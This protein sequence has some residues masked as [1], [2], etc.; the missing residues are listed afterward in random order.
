MSLSYLYL[1]IKFHYNTS[2][3]YNEPNT[4]IGYWKRFFDD[5]NRNKVPSQRPD[6]LIRTSKTIEQREMHALKKEI[7]AYR[8]L[9]LNEQQK[10]GC[11]VAE[12]MR[13]KEKSRRYLLQLQS[14]K[15]C[16]LKASYST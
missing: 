5:A 11:V 16:L 12:L 15:K 4:R 9:Y 13:E 3:N 1:N 2:M 6:P 14:I 10:Q 8:Q 7:D